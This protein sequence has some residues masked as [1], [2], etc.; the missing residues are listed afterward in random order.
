MDEQEI[1]KFIA[2]VL[3][4]P[5]D[6]LDID[7]DMEEIETWDSL[8]NVM[9]FAALEDEYDIDIPDE[10]MFD[11][12]NVRAIVEEVIKLADWQWNIVRY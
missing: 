7:A 6:K 8:H 9:L 5:V 12:V 4:V 11:L 3:E 1:I 10:D 2:D